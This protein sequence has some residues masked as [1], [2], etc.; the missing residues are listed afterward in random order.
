MV[1]NEEDYDV[2]VI[3][4]GISGLLSA[5]ALSKEGKRVLVLEKEGYLG[6]VCR[7]YEVDGY[8]VDKIG[9]AHV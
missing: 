9:R 7:S 8:Y 2:V 4:A 1:S 6:G 5:L 3:G